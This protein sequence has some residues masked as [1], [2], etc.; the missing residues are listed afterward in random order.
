MDNTNY[1][2]KDYYRLWRK[3]Y[4]TSPKHSSNAGSLHECRT[5][6]KHYIHL[7]I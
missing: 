3:L 7:Q 1:I 5:T 4:G 6:P 2:G